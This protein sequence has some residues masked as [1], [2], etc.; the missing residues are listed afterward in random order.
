V[1]I[2]L[3]RLR[4]S[5]VQAVQFTGRN[6]VPCVEIVG[7]DNWDSYGPKQFEFHRD[8]NRLIAKVGDWIIRTGSG[9]LFLVPDEYFG[10]VC[11]PEVAWS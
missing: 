8:G 6:L 7:D 2:G 10:A 9:V 4:R 11:E 5:V 1:T 3:Y